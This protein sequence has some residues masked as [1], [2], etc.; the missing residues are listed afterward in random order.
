MAQPDGENEP[1]MNAP[2]TNGWR[3]KF[4]ATLFALSI[5]APV[6]GIPL[7][8]GFDLSG[9]TVASISGVLLMAGEVLG[10]AA[11]AI[12]G[13]PGYDYL[14]NLFLGTLKRYGPPAQVSRLRYRVGLVMFCIPILF[15]WMT[16]YLSDP[17]DLPE[18]MIAY[19]IA[20]DALLLASLFVLGG[21]FWDKLRSLFIH[22]HK[23]EG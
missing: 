1:G 5:L 22:D 17:L 11:V 23:A 19:A 6:G 13:K 20:G 12:M 18:D 21:D 15:G 7:L 8:A 14:R 4:G 3:L 10:L 9:K 16:P 2:P